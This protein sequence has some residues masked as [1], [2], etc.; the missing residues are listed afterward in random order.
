MGKIYS[1]DFNGVEKKKIIDSL[2]KTLA[3]VSFKIGTY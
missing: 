2:R 3:A 1:E